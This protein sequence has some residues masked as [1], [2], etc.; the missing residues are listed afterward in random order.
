[1]KT[2]DKSK[3]SL[4]A[5]AL[6][7]L[8]VLAPAAMAAQ[9]WTDQADYAPW[10]VV[11]IHGSEFAG[12]SDYTLTIEWPDGYVDGPFDV[13]TDEMGGFTFTY[14]KEKFE[15]TYTIEVTDGAGNTVSATFTDSVT[16]DTVISSDSGGTAK[17]SFLTTENV[18]AFIDSKGG[19]PSTTA[20]IYVVTTVPVDGG[21][22][23]D[24]SGGY[25]TQ[26]ISGDVTVLV[27]AHDTAA[28]TYY[29]VVDADGDG[30]KSANE[31]AVSSSFTIAA[32][33][34]QYL[35]TVISAHGSPTASTL[36]DAGDDFTAS[37]TSPDPVDAGHRWVCT[38][39]S[40]DGGAEEPGTSHTFEDVSAIH[41][42]TFNW[43]EQYKVTFA[44]AGLDASA[45][46]TV[47]SGTISSPSQTISL[48]GNFTNTDYWAAAGA[49]VDYTF[50]DP[51]T[52]SDD[53]TRFV[54][55]TPVP[56]PATGFSV[57]G[58]VTVTG[59]YKTQFEL[60]VNSSPADI[61][62][63]T[64]GGWYDAGTDVTITT[65]SPVT[66]SP[67][68]YF[69]SGWTTA[70]MTEIADPTALSTTVDVDQPKTVTANY[71][72]MIAPTGGHTLGFWSNKNGQALI[73]SG[74][75]TALCALNLQDKNGGNFDPATATQLKNW[76]LKADATYMGY[77]LSAQLAATKLSVLHGF[78]SATQAVWL[79]DGDDVFEPGEDAQTIGSI[80]DAANA[81]LA[82]P[83][84]TRAELEQ[85]KN[86]LDK[87]N[88]N[89]LWFI[90]P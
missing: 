46:G 58:A 90:V 45:M 32:P 51:V 61:G 57:T 26:V 79:D 55:T 25:E 85:L 20:R 31:K 86:E 76:L 28:G 27:W 15:G 75:L 24:V 66:V 53:G 70:D 39:H 33:P 72:R 21:A 65:T 81:A 52:S 2:Q 68:T 83:S 14:E 37:V 71:V 77:M 43:Q 42:I 34:T 48:T 44:Q 50:A 60:V 84:S 16:A 36:V 11:T 30:V 23:T 1:M 56:S 13:T 63:Q 12:S 9:V 59:T 35:I 3:T 69:F 62:T 8:I 29:I 4:F 64:G 78:L 80:M 87:I 54:L 22:L 18:Y 88:N 89:L 6:L 5:V 67:Y 47:V 10:E 19:G 38:G 73:T 49:T 74:D 40:V 17:G 7:S 82:N 41:T